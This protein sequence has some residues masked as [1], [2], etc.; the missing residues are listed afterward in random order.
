MAKLQVRGKFNAL[1]GADVG[2]S[3]EYHVRNRSTRE[4]DAAEELANQIETAMLIGDGHND[5]NWNE[6]HTRDSQG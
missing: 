1:G 5:A 3:H 6:K 2:I 4:D